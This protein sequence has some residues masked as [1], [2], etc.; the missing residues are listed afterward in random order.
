MPANYN[1]VSNIAILE[2]CHKT[3][4]NM[5]IISKLQLNAGWGRDIRS[6]TLTKIVKKKIGNK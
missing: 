1:N 2:F 6:Y 3:T 4:D 5:F